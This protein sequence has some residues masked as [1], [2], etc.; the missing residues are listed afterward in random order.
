M[1]GFFIGIFLNQLARDEK[2][3]LSEVEGSLSART[4]KKLLKNGRLFY[5]NIFEPTCERREACPERSRR[6]SL[7][8]YK[9]ESRLLGVGF[10]SSG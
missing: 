4:L 9:G 2:P 5:W 6:E 8:P 1:G 10:F 3:V 7:R